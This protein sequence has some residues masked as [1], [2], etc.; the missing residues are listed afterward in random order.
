MIVCLSL[1]LDSVKSGLKEALDGYMKQSIS[2]DRSG[3][4]LRASVG[5]PDQ[6]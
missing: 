2:A 4:I 6:S 5:T 1:P 3:L